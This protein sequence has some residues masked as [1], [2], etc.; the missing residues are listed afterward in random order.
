LHWGK[1]PKLRLSRGKKINSKS[2]VFLKH[3]ETIS[4]ENFSRQKRFLKKSYFLGDDGGEKYLFKLFEQGCHAKLINC[5]FFIFT[6]KTK[7]GI[8]RKFV[9]KFEKAIFFW[10]CLCNILFVTNSRFERNWVLEI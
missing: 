2:M 1:A 5:S 10:F 3:K 4:F 8:Q 7:F 6:P 9:T